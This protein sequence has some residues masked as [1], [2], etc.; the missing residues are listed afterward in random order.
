MKDDQ[1]AFPT[2]NVVDITKGMTLRD[3]FAQGAMQGLLSGNTDL[4]D[5]PKLVAE[6]AYE[7]AD[8]MMEARK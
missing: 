5:D 6:W 4:M 3:Y 1:P 7:M 2:W 8:E